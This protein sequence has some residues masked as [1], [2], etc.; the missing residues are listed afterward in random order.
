MINDEIEENLTLDY[1]GADALSK[2]P[3]KKREITK[4]VSAMANSAGG[5]IVY[6]VAEYNDPS[7][8]HLPEKIDPVDRTLFP[9][10]WLEHVINNIRPRINDLKIHSVDVSSGVNEIVY[11]VEIP[12]NDTAHQASDFRYYKR[13][14]F[15][16]VP[17]EDFEVRDVMN[18]SHH[19]SITL[20]FEI[21][22]ETEEGTSFML[23][24]PREEYDR[25]DLIVRARNE[26]V[27]F[28]NYINSFITLPAILFDEEGLR[29]REPF[30]KDGKLYVEAFADNTTRDI[31][32]SSSG[33][34]PVPRYG[35][36]RFEP[37]LP[38]LRSRLS[39]FS[40]REDFESI[41]LHGLE[42]SWTVHADN[43]QPIS[44]KISLTDVPVIDKR[45]SNAA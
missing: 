32:G 3:G 31:V 4:D 37:I 15:E 39:S 25:F 36:A 6:G 23:G 33:Y 34:P 24:M 8:K 26:G 17:M 7:R 19:P 10:E 20:E 43:A 18:R 2:S 38:R 22:I 44:G 30:E 45:G 16:S 5:V 29:Y 9:K 14:N 42:I 13:F 11:V 12:Q 35:P 41:D 27:I 21:E 1:K 28:A 40:L